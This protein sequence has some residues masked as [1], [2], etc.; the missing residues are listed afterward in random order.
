MDIESDQVSSS[1]YDEGRPSN[2]QSEESEKELHKLEEFQ[3]EKENF[4]HDLKK[5]TKT[6]QKSDDKDKEDNL[7]SRM[8]FLLNQADI[9]AH[10]LLSKN[11]KHKTPR[12]SVTGIQKKR[13]YIKENDDDEDLLK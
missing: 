8:K 7:T 5:K 4:V 9:F 12:K 3:K 11:E 1:E 10:F 6:I 13:V 2:N